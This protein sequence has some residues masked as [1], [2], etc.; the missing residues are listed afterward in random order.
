[1]L[2]FVK[3]RSFLTVLGFLLLAVFIWYAGPYF[4]FAD[5]SPLEPVMARVVLFAAIVAIWAISKAVKRLRAYRAGDRLVAAVVRQAS[6]EESHPG[7]EAVQLRERF[8]EAVA[9]L[10]RSRKG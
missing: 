2:A 5:Y 4:A 7:A 10:K 3:R 8:E 1:M 6:P 9:S